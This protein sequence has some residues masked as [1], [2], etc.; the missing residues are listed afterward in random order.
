MATQD[1]P[2]LLPR[3]PFTDD[4]KTVRYSFEFGRG[5]HGYGGT[6]STDVREFADDAAAREHGRRALSSAHL[7]NWETVTIKED[8]P[9][10]ALRLLEGHR[11]RLLGT[12]VREDGEIDWKPDYAPEF[13]TFSSGTQKAGGE[14]CPR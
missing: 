3:E 10:A 2:C 6:T 13:F 5:P 1:D 11:D 8:N 12:W 4:I 7:K 9:L 14:E